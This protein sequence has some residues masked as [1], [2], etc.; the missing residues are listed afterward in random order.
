MVAR[1][2]AAAIPGLAV[3]VALIAVACVVGP[4]PSEPPVPATLRPPASVG[5]LRSPPPPVPSAGP[6]EPSGSLPPT[7]SASS[8]P[9]IAVLKRLPRWAAG[10]YLDPQ[11][12]AVAD[13][14]DVP[15]SPFAA[16]LQRLGA[17]PAAL[18]LALGG[19]SDVQLIAMRLAGTTSQEL[20]DA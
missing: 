10:E 20:A 4:G 18:E 7:P 3:L 2:T 14:L 9:S 17:R 5:A 1:R 11:E 13:V 6:S 12:L 19:G 8:G 16:V 15:K